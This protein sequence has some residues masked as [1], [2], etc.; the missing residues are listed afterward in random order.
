MLIGAG[1]YFGIKAFTK[2][3][4]T[5]PSHNDIENIEDDLTLLDNDYPSSDDEFEQFVYEYDRVMIRLRYILGFYPANVKSAKRDLEKIRRDK[6]G[7]IE[8]FKNWRITRLLL[9][10]IK[11]KKHIIRLIKNLKI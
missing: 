4:T 1:V 6:S 11:L 8:R 10:V 2:P 5:V 3:T 9:L 7:V